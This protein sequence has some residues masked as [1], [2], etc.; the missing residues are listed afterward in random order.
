MVAVMFLSNRFLLSVFL[1]VLLDV[2]IVIGQSNGDFWWLNQK[3]VNRAKDAREAKKSSARVI[4][5]ESEED[6]R[7][8][9]L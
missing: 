2:C 3:L 5:V 8:L 6:I 4:N 7:V 1:V 9:V